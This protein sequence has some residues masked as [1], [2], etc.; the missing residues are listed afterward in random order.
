MCLHTKELVVD[1]FTKAF[2]CSACGDEAR[3]LLGHD[4]IKLCENPCAYWIS[5]F[6]HLAITLDES[7]GFANDA[8]IFFSDLR[9]HLVASAFEPNH[10]VTYSII[11]IL[12]S[13]RG[14]TVNLDTLPPVPDDVLDNMERLLSPVANLEENHFIGRYCRA[15]GL[16]PLDEWRIRRAS[17]NVCDLMCIQTP[18]T[19][20]AAMV[21][22][23][24]QKGKANI[25]R[26]SNKLA[27]KITRVCKLPYGD[28]QVV[29]LLLVRMILE[30]YSG[31]FTFDHYPTNQK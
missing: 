7:T 19:R 13:V 21:Y 1:G 27:Q 8:F 26:P 16:T 2:L 30:K 14:Q 15:M 11:N 25:A 10:L 9:G 20:A 3:S 23:Y 22:V 24:M 17:H 12:G 31:I 18:E 4:E 6:R 28:D 29:M 5:Y